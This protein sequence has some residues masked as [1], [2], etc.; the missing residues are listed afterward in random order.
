MRC[1]PAHDE[2]DQIVGLML[3]QVLQRR[4]FTVT[5]LDTISLASEMVAS[6]DPQ[7]TDVVVISALAP[8]AAMHASYLLKLIVSRDADLRPIVGLW[9]NDKPS[10]VELGSALIVKSLNGLQDQLD[11]ITPMILLSKPPIVDKDPREI[12][13]SAK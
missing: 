1:L 3:A 12:V 10:A 4:G 5:V 11:Q 9:N 13:A 8:K 2:A 7:T 6:I